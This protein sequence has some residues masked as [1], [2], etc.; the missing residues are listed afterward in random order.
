VGK[1]SVVAAGSLVPEGMEVPPATLVMGTPAKP[2]RAVSAEEQARF[3]K[4][5]QSYVERSKIYRES[6]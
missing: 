2:R 4:G 6:T 5:V 3:R 1:G